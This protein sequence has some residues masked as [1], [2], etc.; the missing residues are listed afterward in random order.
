MSMTHSISN[1]MAEAWMGHEKGVAAVS[2]ASRGSSQ[3]WTLS[4]GAAELV[5]DRASRKR[6]APPFCFAGGEVS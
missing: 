4:L 5:T 6:S 2:S 1:E 3:A